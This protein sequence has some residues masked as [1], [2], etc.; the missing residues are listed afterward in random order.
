[1]ADYDVGLFPPRARIHDLSIANPRGFT[2]G[3]AVLA[4]EVLCRLRWRSF[5]LPGLYVRSIEITTPTIR[6][7]RTGD[8][9][10]L[11]TLAHNVRAADDRVTTRSR[12]LERKITIEQVVLEGARVIDVEGNVTQTPGARFRPPDGDDPVGRLARALADAFE[13]VWTH[14]PG[15]TDRLA[16][17][18]DASQEP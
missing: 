6:L 1:M 4:P 8:T 16:E 17:D 13:H 3:T 5:V 18:E 10:N 15:K 9:S 2:S 7:E 14:V 12:A 11:E